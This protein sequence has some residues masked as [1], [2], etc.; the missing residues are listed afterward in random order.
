MNTMQLQILNCALETIKEK[1][2]FC[3]YFYQYI[4]VFKKDSFLS[5]QNLSIRLRS[6]R[7]GT[8]S[9]RFSLKHLS[10]NLQ[11][12]NLHDKGRRTKS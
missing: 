8:L 5:N 11:Q 4:V 1:Y 10:C 7:S 9:F 2:I 3:M 6:L 12:Q